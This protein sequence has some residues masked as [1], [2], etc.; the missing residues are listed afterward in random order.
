MS[1]APTP[2]RIN[3]DASFTPEDAAELYGIN[4]WGN[5]YFT[6][7]ERGT[8]AVRPDRT[9][10]REIDLPELV[11]SMSERGYYTPLL[12]R[13]T[14][15]LHDRLGAIRAAFDRAI[16][17]NAYKG[18]Y[19]CVYPIKVNQHRVV[20]EEVRDAGKKFGFGLEAGSKAEL[21]AVL[22]LT[23][24]APEMPIVCNGFKDDEYIQTV[25][26]AHKLGRNIIP[27]VEQYSDLMRILRIS[28]KYGVRPNIG[29]RI[30]PTASGGSGRWAASTGVR[31]KF[32]LSPTELLR[33]VEELHSRDMADCLKM[34]HFHV[35]SQINEIRRFKNAV[36]ELAYLYV[37]LRRLGAGLDTIDVGGGLGVDY[38]GSSSPTESSMNYTLEEYATD[39]VWRIKAACDAED[40]PH[41]RILSES[42]RA[43]VAHSSVFITDVLGVGSL[44]G[45]PDMVQIRADLKK[46]D[47]EPQPVLDLIDA[48]ESLS[49]GH[50]MTVYHDAEQA[51]AEAMSLF[52]LGYLSLRMRSAAD[53]LYFEIGRE[54]LKRSNAE[55][56]DELPAE[57][58]HLPERLSDLYFCNFSIFQSMPDSWAIDQVFPVMPIH[59]LNEKPDRHAVLADI[60]CDSDGKID[61]FASPHGTK[62]FLD[63]HKLKEGE[64][65]YIAFF[66]VGAYQEVLGDLH[67][68]FGDAHVVHVSLDE[69]GE[70]SI[71]EVVPGDSVRDVLSYV[72][73]EP[74]KLLERLR[75]DVERAQKRRLLTVAEGQSL[76]RFYEAGLSGYTYLEE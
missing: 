61:R 49:G 75:L 37:E 23:A 66:L 5:G 46:E 43:M 27:V 12:V 29:V 33:A 9:P 39:I 55:H 18:E 74:N 26:L 24:D 1:T 32:G 69:D 6:V 15:L 58:A 31:S 30:K 7:T 19:C 52:N 70:P 21:W 10:G 44:P 17:E 56:D 16:E 60:T 20:C 28:E 2:Q 34:I 45:E 51:H 25:V 47:D 54:I 73:F 13:F 36:A 64:V 76:L 14:D 8:V 62:H 68:L 53:R 71:D 38:D 48:W 41:P 42:G 3:S 22:G 72:E 57:L 50:Y 65:Y 40:V 35:G 11:E 63:L 67:N 59:R 4:A